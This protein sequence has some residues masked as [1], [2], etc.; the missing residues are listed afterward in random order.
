M[1]TAKAVAKKQRRRRRC[2]LIK[3][4]AT[5]TIMLSYQEG[6]QTIAEIIASPAYQALDTYDKAWI[7]RDLRLEEES[8]ARLALMTRAADLAERYLRVLESPPKGY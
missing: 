3:R 5:D 1:A 7:M 2:F 8:R 4:G 6:K